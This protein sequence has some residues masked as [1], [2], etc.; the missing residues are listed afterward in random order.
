MFFGVVVLLVGVVFLL[1][2]LGL[3]EGSAWNIVWP[4]VIILLGLS[5]LLKPFRKNGDA[6]KDKK[7]KKD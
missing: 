2:N 7:T 4:I 1:Q 3:I 5:I 6:P